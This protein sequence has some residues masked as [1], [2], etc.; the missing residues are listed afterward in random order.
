MHLE[1]DIDRV[2]NVGTVPAQRIGRAL[3]I[4]ALMLQS[5]VGFAQAEAA[6]APSWAASLYRLDSDARLLNDQ[7]TDSTLRQ[8]VRLSIGGS[9]I[10]IVLSN[11]AGSHPLAVSGIH[12][13]LSGP[14]GSP[15]IQPQSDREVRF[16]NRSDVTVPAGS[17]ILSDAVDLSVPP[18]ARLSVSIHFTV[19]PQDQTGH[20]RSLSTSWIAHGDQLS[21]A[22]L[23]SA[24]S[25][26][27]WYQLEAV[28]VETAHPRVIVAFGD[29]I[30]DGSLST[31]NTN[32]RWPDLLA[33]RL[34]S[35]SASPSWAVVNEGLAGNQLLAAGFGPSALARFD[36]D[37]LSQSY[38]RA[39]V[40]LEGIND[41]GQFAQTNPAPADRL[42]FR[43]RVI[44]AYE[45]LIS[46]AHAHA[47]RLIG[48]TL[49]PYSGSDYHPTSQDESDRRAINE[50][51]RQ[52]G[53]FDAVIDWDAILRDPV[54]P[55]QLEAEFDSGDHI[56][57]SARGYRAMA[58]A[59]PIAELVK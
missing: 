58:D 16:N 31:P 18:L 25:V 26:E 27:H 21:A 14:P 45:S 20:L 32:S 39:V 28:Q 37:V 48:A 11:T 4:A 46:R 54:N 50:W 17:K 3:I 8:S 10:R 57:P 51:I 23:T 59:I 29:S 12:V 7:L 13:A 19:P 6:W 33:D 1:L 22:T 34:Q 42:A 30:T 55:S 44:T 24:T 36:A 41:L 49:L 56:H 43:K 52:P 38:V 35:S 47:I 40:L 5:T 53:H 2:T 15:A 9:R